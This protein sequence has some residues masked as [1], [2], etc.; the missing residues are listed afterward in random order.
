MTDDFN[1][2]YW[3]V[4]LDELSYR[5]FDWLETHQDGHSG[6]YARYTG[7]RLIAKEKLLSQIALLVDNILY[8]SDDYGHPKE[9]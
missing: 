1:E 9:G 8:E 6:H 3:S 7:S 4:S 2:Q 5:V